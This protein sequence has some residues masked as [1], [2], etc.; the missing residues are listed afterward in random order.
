MLFKY[1]I[2]EIG[3]QDKQALVQSMD[4]KIFIILFLLILWMIQLSD[5]KSSEIVNIA[6]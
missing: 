4:Q 6:N 5:S 2:K 3:Q 1:W